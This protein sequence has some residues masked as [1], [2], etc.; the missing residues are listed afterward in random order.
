MPRRAL[1]GLGRD[2]LLDGSKALAS[3]VVGLLVL[4]GCG[5]SDGETQTVTVRQTVE[6]LEAKTV[7]DLEGNRCKADETKF[8]RCPSSPDYGKTMVAARKAKAAR[9]KVKAERAAAEKAEAQ[10]VAAEEAAAAAEAERQANAWKQD[11]TEYS[12]GIAY[13]WESGCDNS[14]TSCYGMRLVTR[15]GCDSLFVTLQIQDSAGN[16]IGTAIDSAT[17]LAPGQVA[18]L[19]FSVLEENASSAKIAEVNCY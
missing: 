16:A 8:G 19:D 2:R 11:F 7:K 6:P 4:A 15:D 9:A 10:R 18:L 17:K 3:L 12:D 13:K 14:Y 1:P 5:G